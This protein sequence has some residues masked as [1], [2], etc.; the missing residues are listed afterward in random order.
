MPSGLHPPVGLPNSRARERH[1]QPQVTLG[2]KRWGR[3]QLG[4]GETPFCIWHLLRC[5]SGLAGNV[6]EFQQT[7]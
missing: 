7:Q 6:A 4:E 3:N 5:W 2:V 1:H